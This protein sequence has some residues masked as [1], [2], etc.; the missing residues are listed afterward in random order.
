M[1]YVN[2]RFNELMRKPESMAVLERM[3][4]DVDEF[5]PGF[6]DSPEKLSG[7]GH[8]YFCNEDGGRL[9]FDLD[10]PH[11]HKC[12]VCGKEFE[13]PYLDKVWTTFYR[14]RAVVLTMVSAMIYRVTGE[15]KYYDHAVNVIDWYAENYHLFPLHNKEDLIFGSLEEMKWGCG[16]VMPQNLNEAIIAIRFIQTI[17]ILREDLDPGWIDKLHKKLFRPIYELLRPQVVQIH[18]ISAWEIAAIGVMG[19]ALDDGEMRDFAFESPL[20]IHEQLRRGVTGDSFWYEGSIHYNFFLLEGVTCLFLFARI[21]GHDM[22]E[23]STRILERMFVNA[24]DYAFDSQYLPNPNDGWPNINLKTYGCVYHT[25]ARF[26][27]E[28]SPV[29]NLTKLIEAS[30]EPRTTLPLSEP[31]YCF[32][33]I[34]MERLLFNIDFNYADFHEVPRHSRVFPASN[35]AMLRNE[36]WNVFLKY[37]LNG[38]SHRHPDIMGVEV[39]CKGQRLSRDLS[40]PG[41]RSRLCN[42]WHRTTVCHNT[43]CRNGEDITS[44]SPG[45][46]LAFSEYAVRATARDVY[47]GTDFTRAIEITP[48]GYSDLF[49]VCGEAGVYDWFFHL[50]PEIDVRCDLE[51][52][53]AGLGFSENGYQHIRD[54]RRFKSEGPVTL[55]LEDGDMSLRLTVTPEEGQKV[56]IMRTPDN[57]VDRTRT[58]LMVRSCGQVNKFRL[59]IEIL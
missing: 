49:S 56:F 7:W 45:E 20:N 43:V 29:G 31:Y 47:E 55:R 27:G 14:N 17:E 4:A 13:D 50:E 25:A 24:Y 51:T 18:N 44:V 6:S 15:R 52:E 40:N 22:G 32:N 53:T 57:P 38:R 19:L 11:R 34:C 16:R 10:S 1:R 37:G 3:R 2:E 58:T 35:F 5:M 33:R 12:T 59:N 42:E 36:S 9:I 8:A 48:T 46:C 41:Y 26:F 21:Y 23:E 54:V 28:D 39:M 30:P